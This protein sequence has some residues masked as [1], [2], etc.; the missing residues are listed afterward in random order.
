MQNLFDFMFH[1]EHYVDMNIFEK[2]YKAP[3]HTKEPDFERVPLGIRNKIQMEV[4][5]L[6]IGENPTSEAE[7]KWSEDYGALISMFIDHKDHKVL[8][9]LISKRDIKGAAEEIV[10]LINMAVAA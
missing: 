3:D 10:S 2:A 4:L 1:V 7:V 9:G 6:M 5:K 8:R